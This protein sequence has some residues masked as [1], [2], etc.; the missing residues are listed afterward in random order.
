MRGGVLVW[1]LLVAACAPALRVQTVGE[2]GRGV[3]PPARSRQLP[4]PGLGSLRQ[5][6]FT[7]ELAS[8]PLRVKVTPLAE[9]VI[10]LAAPDTYERLH[11]LVESTG[12]EARRQAGLDDAALF[13][14]SFFSY[15]PDV[16]F[17]PESL[18]LTHQGR[19]M[20]ARAMV[21][22]GAGWGRQRLRQQETQSAVYAF[23][24][25]VDYDLALAVRY[26]M[27]RSDAW[28]QVIPLLDRERSRVRTRGGTEGGRSRDRGIVLL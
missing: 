12:S 24:G 20:H 25:P 10:R 19:V 26:E 2:A 17:R 27:A 21:P 7:V 5:D 22:L 15:E 3:A 4:P 8:G 28:L 6:E 1:A 23:Q 11:R 14:V 18:Q 16:V 13:L 9:E